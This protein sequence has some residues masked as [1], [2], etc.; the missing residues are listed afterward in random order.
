MATTVLPALTG[1]NQ[2]GNRRLFLPDPRPD[3]FTGAAPRK[4]SATAWYPTTATGPPARYLS[5]TDSYDETMA[6]ALTNGLENAGCAKSWWN[7]AI[8]CGGFFG[9]VDPNT[10]M[11]GNI[12]ARDTRAVKDAP[13]RTDLAPLPVV[14]VSPGFGMPGHTS[15]ILAQDLASHGWLVFTLSHTYESISTEWSTGVIAQNAGYVNQQWA[16]CLTARVGDVR[17]LLNQLPTLPNGIGTNADISRL[18]IVGHSY[19]GTTGMEVAYL[20]PQRVKAVALLD[21]PVGYTDTSNQAQNNGITQPVMLLSGPVDAADGITSGAEMPGWSTYTATTHGPLHRY[22]VDGAK[23]HA[24]TD[25]GLLTRKPA[26][27]LGTITAAR[28]MNLTPRWVRAFLDTYILASTDPLLTLPA[29]DWPEI[30]AVL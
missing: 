6:L 11:Y 28:A 18:A 12:R 24:F 23:H 22:Q 19:G 26:D 10:T 7:G 5:N 17:Y 20:E 1:P 15:S 9:G 27:F 16:K 8:T 3:P 14:I 13:V 30:T 21:G 29:V 25:I 4:I 2:V